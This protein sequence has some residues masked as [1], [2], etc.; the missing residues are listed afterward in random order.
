MQSLPEICYAILFLTAQSTWFQASV[1]ALSSDAT[2]SDYAGLRRVMLVACLASG[3]GMLV[4]LAVILSFSLS[5]LD[6]LSF[7]SIWRKLQGRQR[8]LDSDW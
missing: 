2:M 5:S 1:C 4:S 6:L 8:G 3:A 7:K